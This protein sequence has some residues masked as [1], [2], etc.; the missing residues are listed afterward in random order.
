MQENSTADRYLNHP[1]AGGLNTGGRFRK[2]LRRWLVG[3]FGRPAGFWG[4]VAGW[5]MAHRTTNVVRNQWT[6]ELLEI[7]PD[8]RILEIGFGPGLAIAAV[9]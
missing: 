8:D 9:A 3:Q 1:V 6:T 2:R 4:H 7:N 5:I